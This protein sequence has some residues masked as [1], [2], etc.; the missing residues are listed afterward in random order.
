MIYTRQTTKPI[1]MK[2]VWSV[3]VKTIVLTPPSKV[4]SRIISRITNVVAINGTPIL[5]RI[6]IC[7][8]F[9][10]RY[11]LAVAPNVLEIMK[12]IAPVLYDVNPNRCN[13]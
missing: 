4:Y 10:T 3:S 11:N 9:I 6:N 1:N 2:D 13:R 7:N 5:S 8:T 12:N